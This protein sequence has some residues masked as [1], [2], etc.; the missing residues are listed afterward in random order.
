MKVGY[1]DS[2]AWLIGIL[3]SH[4][5]NESPRNPLEHLTMPLILWCKER[6]ATANPCAD[7]D[8]R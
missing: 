7:S 3:G 4:G 8:L 5:S 2:R 6:G 1:I